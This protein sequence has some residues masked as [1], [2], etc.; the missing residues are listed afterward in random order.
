[1]FVAVH[2]MPQNA[3]QKKTFSKS[4]QREFSFFNSLL[5]SWPN[6]LQ[7]DSKNREKSGL[8][9]KPACVTSRLKLSF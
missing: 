3:K 2:P 8:S 7:A 6:L 9:E 5:S 4:C 1:M